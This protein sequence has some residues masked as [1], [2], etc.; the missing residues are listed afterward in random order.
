MLTGIHLGHY[1][2]DLSKGRPKT[3]WTRLWHLLE[4]L[5]ELAGR[6]PHPAEQSRSRGG[7][8]RFGPRVGGAAASRAAS[9]SVFAER[10]GSHSRADEAALP[11][12]G[13]PGALLVFGRRW[14]A[15]V[16]HR[17][18][19][20]LPRRDATRI[21]RR[22]AVLCAKPAFARFTFFHIV[23][24]AGTAA[25][26][27]AEQIHPTVIEDRRRRLAELDRTVAQ[28]YYRKLVGRSL[29]VIV[30]GEDP[31]RP[32]FS[33]G[34]SCRHVQVSFPGHAPALVGKRVVFAEN[35]VSDGLI[36]Q[37]QAYPFFGKFLVRERDA[38]RYH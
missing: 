36:G 16:Y 12:R 38:L 7:A 19:C 8:R 5:D 21:S 24:R 10:L 37:P 26:E 31:L 29:N 32:G 1:G 28:E 27:F 11:Q 13:F 23:R 17:H 14:I 35:A 6:L 33:R 2:M 22:H 30:E 9:A 20:R 3:R 25:A 15:G 18:D 4:R 34:T